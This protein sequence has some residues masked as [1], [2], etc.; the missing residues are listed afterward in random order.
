M[1]R[2]IARSLRVAGTRRP[3]LPGPAPLLKLAALPMTLLPSPP[4]TPDAVDFINQ[5]AVVDTAPLLEA[6]PRRLATLE[7]GLATYLGP[8]DLAARSITFA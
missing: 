6:L 4:L 3:I 5:P 1:R 7:E 2:I 8:T